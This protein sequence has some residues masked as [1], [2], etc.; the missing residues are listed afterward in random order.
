MLLTFSCESKRLPLKTSSSMPFSTYLRVSPNKSLSRFPF[1]FSRSSFVLLILASLSI[2][3]FY[4]RFF[5]FARDIFSWKA[6][7]YRSRY[8]ALVSVNDC[9]FWQ[10]SWRRSSI[11]FNLEL[12]KADESNI[13]LGCGTTITERSCSILALCV[14]L[15]NWPPKCSWLP[16][17][18]AML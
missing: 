15:S 18:M 2:S 9:F 16:L 7:K 1:F 11:K 8:S 17:R 3:C 14:W 6:I 12:M 10:V 4:Y 5:Y 13:M